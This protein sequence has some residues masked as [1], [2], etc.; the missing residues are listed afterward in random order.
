MSQRVPVVVDP[1]M[2]ATAGARLLA[3]DALA[4]LR[5]RLLPL[6]CLITPNLPEAEALAGMTIADVAAM[7]CGAGDAWA[8]GV[9]AVLLKGGPPAG[10]A[11][12]GPAGDGRR[13]RRV[14]RAAHRHAPHARHRLHA[15]E[16]DGGGAGA[17]SSDCATRWC[18]RGPT[19]ARRSPP[20]GIRRRAWAA[21]PPGWEMERVSVQARSGS[22][23]AAE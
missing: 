19:C 5:R 8:L 22:A 1:V 11:G 9:P 4:M 18:A 21:E 14:C 7:H 17:G 16:R 2:V 3:P 23:S 13:R 10:R 12:G 6:A 15:G 20:P